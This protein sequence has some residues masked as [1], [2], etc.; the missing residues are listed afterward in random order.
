MMNV[1]TRVENP[2]QITAPS[3]GAI[4]SSTGRRFKTHRCGMTAGSLA[5]HWFLAL[6]PALIALL[7]AASLA[8]LSSGAVLRLVNGLHKA[9]PPGA[10]SVFTQAVHSAVSR[11][12]A[13]LT[14]VVIGVVVALWSASSGMVALETGLDVAYE[15]DA[16]RKFVGKRLVAVPLMFATLVLGG[17][18]A[19]LIVFGQPIGSA[20]QSNV[21]LT[22]TGFIVVW[23]VVRWLLTIFAITTLFSV[24]YFVGPNRRAPRWRWVSPGGLAATI[25]FLAASVGF[26]YYVANFGSY[27]KTYGALAGVVILIFWLYLIGIAIMLGAELN[28]S[29]ERQ[30]AVRAGAA[31]AG[32]AAMKGEDQWPRQSKHRRRKR[33]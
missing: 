11:S 1:N 10:S 9:L 33:T 23:T 22:G 24:Y 30:A 7:G 15:V 26:S 12:S 2:A 27:G 5:Y 8:H 25:V 18:A 32:D 28:A 19:A 21:P 13:S 17:I 3:W 31:Q 29:S 4:I 20:I 14:A 16:D 6:F